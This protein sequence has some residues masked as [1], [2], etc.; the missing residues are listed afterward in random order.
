MTSLP[1]PTWCSA[2]R[3]S[4]HTAGSSGM[5]GPAVAGRGLAGWAWPAGTGFA[6][7]TAA[8]PG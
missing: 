2:A 7:C 4:V 1:T 8:D 5:L 3:V 6:G